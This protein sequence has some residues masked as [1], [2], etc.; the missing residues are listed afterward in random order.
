MIDYMQKGGPLMWL[1]LFCSVIFMAVFLE[2]LTYFHRATIRVGEFLRGLSNLVQ[3]R[4]FARYPDTSE[5]DRRNLSQLLFHA[6]TEGFDFSAEDVADVAGPLEYTVITT[7]D[8]DPFDETS[9]LWREMWGQRHLGYPQLLAQIRA[10]E[11]LRRR[12]ARNLNR[13][14]HHLDRHRG[15]EHHQQRL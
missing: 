11:Y 5:Y 2:R 9:R 10:R 3:R 12:G 15:G 8:H 4:S 6:R 1:I 7:K 13:W 14:R